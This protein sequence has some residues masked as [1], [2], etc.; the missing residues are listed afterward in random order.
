[1]CRVA[2]VSLHAS[3]GRLG[4]ACDRDAALKVIEDPSFAMSLGPD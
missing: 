4:H 2:H 1:M 3:R